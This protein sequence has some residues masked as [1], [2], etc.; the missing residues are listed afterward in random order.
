MA[1]YQ[2]TT[3]NQVLATKQKYKLKYK[4]KYENQM[5]QEKQEY[6]QIID[7]LKTEVTK[8]E[9]NYRQQ[10]QDMISFKAEAE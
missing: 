5:M 1:W 9:S 4:T 8:I 2:S 6:F 7:S 10:V 3:N